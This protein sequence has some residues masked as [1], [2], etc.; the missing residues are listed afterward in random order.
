MSLHP[1]Y[2]CNER[3][4]TITDTADPTSSQLIESSPSHSPD[5][6]E[7][8]APDLDV[9]ADL[10]LLIDAL[11]RHDPTA[12]DEMLD[13]AL[14]IIRDSDPLPLPRLLVVDGELRRHEIQGLQHINVVVGC[15]RHKRLLIATECLGDHVNRRVRLVERHVVHCT[16][17]REPAL[18]TLTHQKVK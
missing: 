7:R 11:E 6:Q 9:Y 14:A 12:L 16:E 8:L 4:C 18:L 3:A 15:G 10:L 5:A 13:D 1:R 17:Q 2:E